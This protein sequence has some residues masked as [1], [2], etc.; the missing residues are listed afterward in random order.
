M[1]EKNDAK[2]YEYDGYEVALTDLEKEI[3]QARKDALKNSRFRL[4]E[5]GKTAGLTF[6]GKAYR[7][8]ATGIDDNNNAYTAEK[9]DFELT[10]TVAEG[11][12]SG[13]HKFFSIGSKNKI[14]R[15]IMANLKSGSYTMLISR[16]GEG[17][18]TK[19]SLTTPE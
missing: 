15:E 1:D 6:T 9:I 14:A 2:E 7:R 13:K 3:E 4:I 19:Y 5:A 12:D 11:K 8:T 16:Q 10:D 17:K 18:S